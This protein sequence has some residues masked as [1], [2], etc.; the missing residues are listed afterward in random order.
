V[1][2]SQEPIYSIAWEGSWKVFGDFKQYSPSKIKLVRTQSYDD[3]FSSCFLG[4]LQ[5]ILTNKRLVSYNH[6]TKRMNDIEWV[7][8]EEQIARLK[9]DQ[10]EMKVVRVPSGE[11][12]LSLSNL[13]VFVRGQKV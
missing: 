7:E 11:V 5:F 13:C 12:V 4:E 3:D 1:A 8:R 10:I 2:L 9:D 6:R